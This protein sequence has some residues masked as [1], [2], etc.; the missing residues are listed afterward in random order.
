[1]RCIFRFLAAA[2]LVPVVALAP[3]EAARADMA[4]SMGDIY[5]ALRMENLAPSSGSTMFTSGD[6]VYFAFDVR[7]TSSTPLVV[8]E[9]YDYG[10]LFYLVGVLQTWVERLG[11]DPTIP[12]MWWAG[13]D[14]NRYAAGGEIFAVSSN[15]IPA[16]GV[17]QRSEALNTAGFPAG[18][19]RYYV[20]YKRLWPDGGSVIQTLTVDIAN[21]TEPL[22]ST[23]PTLTVPG[24]VVVEA[25]SASG[26][27]VNYSVSATDAVDPSPVIGCGPA[28][29]TMFPLGSTTVTCNAADASGNTATATFVVRVRD[30]TPPSL[31]V[32]PDVVLDATSPAGVYVAVTATATDAVDPS[33][34]VECAPTGTLRVGDTTVACTASDSSGNLTFGSVVVHVRGAAEQLSALIDAV[35]GTDA[36]QGI[37]TSLDAKLEA[38]REALSA[39]NAGS[40]A[41]ACTKLTA[42]NE[43]VTAQSGKE[44][45]TAQARDLGAAATRIRAVLGCTS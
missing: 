23:P 15:T 12:S 19:Y 37:V 2:T 8:P 31:M 20:Q 13:R 9:N 35:V 26:A 45:T 11:P 3:A 29:G 4:S 17:I 16:G 25:T 7:N 39:A 30:T 44:L 10:R 14:G 41:D 21:T 6:Y 36:K 27:F 43:E 22:D 38:V 40:R 34:S 42:F 18:H 5:A 24:D 32:P 33:P 1:M 28:S